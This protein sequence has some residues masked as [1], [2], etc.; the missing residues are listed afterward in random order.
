MLCAGTGALGVSPGITPITS[1]V[2]VRKPAASIS[3]RI[4]LGVCRKLVAASRA[5]ITGKGSFP[6]RYE[7]PTR[8]PGIRLEQTQFATLHQ[9]VLPGLS[10][11]GYSAQV[12]K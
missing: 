2:C 5:H 7:A 8:Q 11:H 9:T 10:P 4:S 3:A 12:Q 1:Q 6:V